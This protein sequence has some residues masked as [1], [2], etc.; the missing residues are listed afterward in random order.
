MLV[1]LVNLENLFTLL[2]PRG[3]SKKLSEAT[4]ISSGNISDWKKGRSKPT[5]EALTLIAD[6][7]D[8][9][10]DYLLGREPS[11]ETKKD[12]SAKALPSTAPLSSSQKQLVEFA[13]SLTEEEVKKVLSYIRFVLSERDE[14]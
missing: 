7:F 11:S 2:Q 1:I 14:K 10:V 4:G 3:I 5:A 6:Y 12:G 13:E 8:V 9:S